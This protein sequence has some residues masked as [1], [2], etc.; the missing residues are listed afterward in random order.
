MNM[1]NGDKSNELSIWAEVDAFLE[2]TAE[3]YKMSFGMEFSSVIDWVADFSP[4][5]GHP[6]ARDYPV[7]QASGGT[8]EEALRR[9]LERAKQA[10]K[11]HRE[12]IQ[13]QKEAK[14]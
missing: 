7:W 14:R 5:R 9:A 8:R 2:D 13:G 10:V 6:R 12:S 4:R 11:E 1:D 3:E